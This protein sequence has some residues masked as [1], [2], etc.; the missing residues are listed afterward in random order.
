MSLNFKVLAFFWRQFYQE[1]RKIIMKS[2]SFDRLIGF[3]PTTTKSYVAFLAF[4][5][6]EIV[7]LLPCSRSRSRWP[8]FQRWLRMSLE[9]FVV[10]KN[11]A[12]V[13]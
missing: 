8:Y 5:A 1:I 9:I 10:L 12:L 2:S 7:A 3:S 4:K 6:G 13:K 11:P